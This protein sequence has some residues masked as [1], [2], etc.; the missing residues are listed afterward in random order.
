MTF[1]NILLTER[2]PELGTVTKLCV[3]GKCD[4]LPWCFEIFVVQIN[5]FF[6]IP[7]GS[8]TTFWIYFPVETE[9]VEFLVPRDISASVRNGVATVCVRRGYELAIPLPGVGEMAGKG[10]IMKIPVGGLK[11]RVC[12]GKCPCEGFLWLPPWVTV[13]V[14][15]TD[16]PRRPLVIISASDPNGDIVCAGYNAAKGKLPSPYELGPVLEA[17]GFFERCK[18]EVIYEPPSKCDGITDVVMGWAKD[19]KELQGFR[20]RSIT[21]P[22]NRPPVAEP[23]V[24]RGEATVV[25]TPTPSGVKITPK[26]V[27]FQPI[28]VWDPDGDKVTIEGYGLPPTYAASLS[29]FLRSLV[30][31]QISRKTRVKLS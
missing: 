15:P 5:S 28:Q 11:G 12:M 22:A 30:A 23:P 9:E 10:S 26:A 7:Y 16:N 2:D 4:L 8:K 29:A 31:P 21:I 20:S 17:F 1:E 27:V 25:L 14:R 24:L 18:F 3:Q 6:F 13:D 19:A